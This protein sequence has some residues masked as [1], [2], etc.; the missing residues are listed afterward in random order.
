MWVQL[1][2]TME[3]S[4]AH[5]LRDHPGNCRNLHGHTWKLE[6]TVEAEVQEPSGLSMDF[7][8]LKHLIQV[9][10][11]N[12]LDHSYLNNELSI[13][14]PTAEHLCVWIWNALHQ[15]LNEEGVM[16]HSIT[17]WE[18]SDS[19]CYIDR[20]HFLLGQPDQEWPDGR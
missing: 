9:H 5:L 20:G 12:R 2:K 8:S 13:P 4:A 16:L 6:V 14:N 19:K 18:S 3:F 10:V 1:S 15:V 17:L 11:I 7:K